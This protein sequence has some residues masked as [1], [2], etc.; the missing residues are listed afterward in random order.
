MQ[1][2]PSNHSQALWLWSSQQSSVSDWAPAAGSL[3]QLWPTVH[4]KGL[5]AELDFK[6]TDATDT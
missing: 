1:V 5:M 2:A 6:S 3:S 4:R